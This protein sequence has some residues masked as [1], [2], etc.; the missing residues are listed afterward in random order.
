[1]KI[2]ITFLVCT[3]CLIS[4]VYC[5]E[6][7]LENINETNISKSIEFAIEFY[8]L[9]IAATTKNNIYIIKFINN[10]DNIIL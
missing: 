3:F 5:E 8:N 7:S 6:M 10:L 9:I 4:L 1:M 2:I